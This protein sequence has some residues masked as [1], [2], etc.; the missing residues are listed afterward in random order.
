MEQNN[1]KIAVNI[2]NYTG[3][4]PIE[5]ILR[6]GV[7]PKVQQLELKEPESINV[8]GVLSTPLDWL[9]KRI[10]TIE[11]KKANIVV[12]RE[13]MTITLT[14]NESDYYTKSTFVGK[15]AYS[16]IFEKFHINDEK[17]GWIPAKLGQ[18]LRRNRAV[19]ADKSENM[20]L[21]SALKNFTANA[22]SE[23]EKQRDPS[24]SRADV[25]RTQVESNLPKSFTVNLSI[26]RVRR[27]RLLRWSLTITL[28]TVMCSYS[29]YRLVQRKWQMNTV[30]VALMMCWLKFVRLRPTLQS[31]KHNT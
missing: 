20:K 18:F 15:A 2:G 14:I 25:Y 17:M 11:Q 7:A 10:D 31:W 4:K 13:E 23:I 28:Q 21:V 29:L 16:E 19:F 1:E 9:T 26:S 3:E 30:T 6:E 24:G 27:K 22:K 8:T 12:N 5:V